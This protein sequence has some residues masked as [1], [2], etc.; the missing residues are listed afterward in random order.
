MKICSRTEHHRLTLPLLGSRYP[1][2]P[3][4]RA[5]PQLP[6][7]SPFGLLPQPLPQPQPQP[8]LQ[9][10]LPSPLPSGTEQPTPCGLSFA[11]EMGMIINIKDNN[12]CNYVLST[13][14]GL[15]IKS[16][17]VFSFNS[18]FSG[19]LSVPRSSFSSDN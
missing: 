11:P 13:Y 17:A 10:G 8:Q 9:L 5:Q 1:C 3:N 6:L 19:A 16:I 7:Q 14:Y 2:H 12:I 18:W 4:S 15:C